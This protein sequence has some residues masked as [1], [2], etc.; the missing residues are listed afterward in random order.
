MLYD[1]KW[2]APIQDAVSE[3]L[4]KAAQYLQTNGWCRGYLFTYPKGK[5]GRACLLGALA[6]TTNESVVYN[7]SVERLQKAIKGTDI[8]YWNDTLCRSGKHAI[9]V[10]SAATNGK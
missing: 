2:D 7:E 8:A 3:H 4:Q 9:S 5:R 10:L 1:T 6:A